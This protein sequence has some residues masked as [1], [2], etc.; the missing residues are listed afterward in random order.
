MIS[1]IDVI[2]SLMIDVGSL[3]SI[4]TVINSIIEFEKKTRN[5]NPQP[6]IPRESLLLIGTLIAEINILEKEH[7]K[8]LF[9]AKRNFN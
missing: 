8:N 3:E 7:E 5:I 6:P 1:D 4:K 2:N 9:F